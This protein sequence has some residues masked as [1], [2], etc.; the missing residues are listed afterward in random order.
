[1][2]LG[3]VAAFLQSIACSAARMPEKRM[4]AL[5]HT[6]A[7]ACALLLGSRAQRVD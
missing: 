6:D 5:A 4:E 7:L 3:I 1:M 2:L